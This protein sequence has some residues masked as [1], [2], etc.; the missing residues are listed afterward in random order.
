M[1]YRTCSVNKI[2]AQI[3]R[4][5]KPSNSNFVGDAIEWIGDA[6]DIMK[7]A[8]GYGEQVKEV[9]ISDYR[10][11]LP[12]SI[13]VLLGIS[14]NGFRLPRNGGLNH[15]NLKTSKV[16]TFPDCL[17]ESYTLNPNYAN[18]SF[19][20]GCIFVYYLGIETDCDGSPVVIDDAIYR[21]ALSWYVLMKMLGRGFK[22]QVFTYVDAETR[23]KKTYRQAQNRCRMPDIDGYETFKKSWTGL[24]NSNDPTTVFFNSIDFKKL[25]DTSFPPGSFLQTFD[26]IGTNLNN[27]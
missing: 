4:D 10:G 3:Y 5:Y 13:D 12:C 15:R 23:W 25:K 20:E 19:K 18:T 16:H 14:H 2:I 17:T 9:T 11:K 24:V 27:V 8:G 1:V 22:H 26:P 21:E 7:C 6:I